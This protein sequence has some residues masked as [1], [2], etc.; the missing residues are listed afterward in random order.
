MISFI[1]VAIL[2]IINKGR[3]ERKQKERRESLCRNKA[4]E[5]RVESVRLPAS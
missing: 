2:Y 5:F 1:K 4:C 3:L